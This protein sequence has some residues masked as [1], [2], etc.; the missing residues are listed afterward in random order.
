MTTPVLAM[1]IGRHS[2][3][4]AGCLAQIA[5]HD[6]LWADSPGA[7]FHTGLYA[8][9]DHADPQ[10]SAML[11]YPPQDQRFP[12]SIYAPSNDEGAIAEV[13]VAV[14]VAG[15]M[16]RSDLIQGRPVFSRELPGAVLHVLDA[17]E[18]H[19]RLTTI[20]RQLDPPTRD[21]RPCSCH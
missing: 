8:V 5:I 20:C 17:T 14:A 18:A 16:M 9:P 2:L 3:T 12:L 4:L 1:D 13:A 19:K 21:V 15:C 6:I 7:G 10:A 11:Y